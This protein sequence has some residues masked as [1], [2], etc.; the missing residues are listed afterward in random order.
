[1]LHYQFE[2]K[3]SCRLKSGGYFMSK[4]HEL[5]RQI[6]LF[7]CIWVYDQQLQRR[8]FEKTLDLQEFIHWSRGKNY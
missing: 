5:I 3:R 4:H 1:M 8:L 6:G 7:S 2:L